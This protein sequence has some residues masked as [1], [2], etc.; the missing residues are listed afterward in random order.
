MSPQLDHA[1]FPHI[2][3]LIVDATDNDGKIVLRAVSRD[4]KRRTDAALFAHIELD[5]DPF[6]YTLSIRSPH[7]KLPGPPLPPS[8]PDFERD[9]GVWK[10]RLKLARVLDVKTDHMI[11]DD[12]RDASYDHRSALCEALGGLQVVRRCQQSDWYYPIN[13]PTFVD[14]INR[15]RWQTRGFAFFG[16]TWFPSMDSVTK[17]VGHIRYDP[18]YEGLHRDELTYVANARHV[19]FIFSPIE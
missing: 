9:P 11:P 3:D 13:A 1:L 10:E 16:D 2:F 7:G 4:L 8:V 17:H 6:D 12:Q 5:Q 15:D 18:L 14:V 19:V